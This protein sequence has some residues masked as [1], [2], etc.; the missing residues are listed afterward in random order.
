MSSRTAEQ[1][2]TDIAALDTALRQLAMGQQVVKLSY[3]GNN[4][5]YTAGDIDTIK[6]L[7]QA[8]KAELDRV[9]NVYRGPRRVIW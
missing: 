9:T 2:E 7:L 5:E 8:D 3:E 6:Q 1:I 4:V